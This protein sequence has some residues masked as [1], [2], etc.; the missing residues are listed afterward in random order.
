MRRTIAA[1]AV[2]LPLAA[3]CSEDGPV[4]PAGELGIEGISES[5]IVAAADMTDLTRA[6][7]ERVREILRTARESLRALREAVRNG[8]VTIEEA[9]TRARMI[10]DDTIAALSG[11]VSDD[12]IARLLDRFRHGPR[13]GPPRARPDLD[14]TEDQRTAIGVLREELRTFV[15]EIRAAVRAGEME[16][17]EGRARVR[18]RAAETRAAVCEVLTDEQRSEVRFCSS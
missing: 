10:H 15:A 17:G 3:A 11:I 14:L 5:E 4:G 2:V 16:A 6:D 8:N 7:R 12:Q 13:V 18:E 1:L 9:R